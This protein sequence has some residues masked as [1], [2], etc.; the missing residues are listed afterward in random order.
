MNIKMNIKQLSFFS[1]AFAISVFSCAQNANAQEAKPLLSGH[2]ARRADAPVL[3]APRGWKIEKRISGDLNRDKI[4]DA[5]LVLVQDLVAKDAEGNATARQRALVVALKEGKGW[6]RVGFNNSLLLGTRDGG[7]FYGMMETPVD[8]SIKSGILRVTQDNGS[9]EVTNTTHKFRLDKR[10][11]RVYLIGFDMS[12]NDRLTANTRS[13]SS[14][15]LTGAKKITIIK[16]EGKR[17]RITYQTA[18]VSRKLRLLESV[19]V[20]ERYSG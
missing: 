5:A 15:Y 10:T 2:I 12:E 7:A 14:N 4:P 9:R 17:E 3:F 8:V 1:A 6:H 18:R 16:G 19:K 13:Q 20:E 11:Q